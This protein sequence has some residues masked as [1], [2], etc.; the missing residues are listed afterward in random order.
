VN[1]K[2]IANAGKYVGWC[3]ERNTFLLLKGTHSAGWN[4]LTDAEL[5]ACSVR[6]ISRLDHP[7]HVYWHI[8]YQCNLQ[9]LHC[10]ASKEV[11]RDETLEVSMAIILEAILSSKVLKVDFSGGEPLL[12]GQLF[13]YISMIKK[14]GIGTTLTSNG[15]LLQSFMNEIVEF[16]DWIIISLDG[17]SPDT[18]DRLRGRQGTFKHAVDSAKIFS[19][20]GK[21][22][23]INTIV[24]RQNYH[25]VRDIA[26]L[27]RDLGASQITFMHFIPLGL[28]LLNRG[29]YEISVPRFRAVVEPVKAELH[30]R[31]FI[32]NASDRVRYTGFPAI[33]PDGSVTTLDEK[34]QRINLGSLEFSSLAELWSGV[35]DLH[36]MEFSRFK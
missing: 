19:K 6:G 8:T 17:S 29:A 33:E 2:I 11:I 36:T 30:G 12:V 7:L 15:W 25:E 34:G 9:C 14:A 1:I 24:S 5:K 35:K 27:A 26:L 28:G 22:V 4:V 21:H 16:V 3:P 13:K 23:R 32:V 20:L 18:H 31:D 10:F